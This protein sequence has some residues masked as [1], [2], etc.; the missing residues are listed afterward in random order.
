MNNGDAPAPG[1]ASA[2]RTYK[3]TMN[4]K[5]ALAQMSE[6]PDAQENLRK[7]KEYMREAR[8]VHGASLIVFPE[9]YMQVLPHGSGAAAIVATAQSLDGP[10]VTGMRAYAKEYGLWTVFGM[11]EKIPGDA[12]HTKNTVVVLDDAGELRATYSKTHLFDGLGY[13]ESK[14]VMQ[15][16]ELF[17]VIDTPFG[18]MGLFVCYE[19]RFPEVARLQ[20]LE[21]ADLIV[22]P[23][24]WVRGKNK[25]E[26]LHTLVRAR[27][28]E[29]EIF[30]ICCDLTGDVSMGES[31]VA[32]PVGNVIAQAGEGEELLI[33]EIDTG[34]QEKIRDVL[35]AIAGRRTDLYRL[36][37]V[38]VE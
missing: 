23:A 24:A 37:K 16:G 31:L 18:K 25:G 4:Y 6:C 27:A 8:E 32:D 36:E 21:G 2:Q 3:K 33:A 13:T 15:G 12:E 34:V 10:F 30:L 7:S 14:H 1:D 38:R 11:R 35:P 22:M 19:L 26:Q 17:H 20:M 29:N 28:V 5:I 9:C